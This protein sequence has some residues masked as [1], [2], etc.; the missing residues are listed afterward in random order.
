MRRMVAVFALLWVAAMPVAA[1][2][3]E[4]V[5]VGQVWTIRDAHRSE[6][7]LVVGRI[8]PWKNGSIAIHVSLSGL[9]D[10]VMKNG[11]TFTGTISHMPFERSVLI[12]SLDQMTGADAQIDPGFQEGYGEWQSNDGGIFTISVAEAISLMLSMLQLDTAGETI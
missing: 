8:E 11:E 4:A 3:A 5:Q 12:S 6:V 7:R 2:P 1:D 10:I 9:G